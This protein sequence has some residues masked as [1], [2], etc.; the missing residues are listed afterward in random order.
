[1]GAEAAIQAA[2]AAEA[3]GP[4]RAIEAWR[5]V[6]QEHGD[7]RTPRRELARVLR[8]A[9]KWAPLV[10]ALKEEEQ[11]L[12]SSPDEQVAVLRELAG[13]YRQLRNDLTAVNTLGQVLKIN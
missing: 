5:K 11:K 8:Q 4:D 7:L 10:E 9:E 6:I 12:A 2:R 13:A 3:Q 1:A